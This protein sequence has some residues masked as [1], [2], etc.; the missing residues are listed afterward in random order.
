MAN[1]GISTVYTRRVAG[2]TLDE[3][4]Y[5]G[6]LSMGMHGHEPAFLSAVMT[7]GFTERVALHTTNTEPL[8]VVVRPLDSEHDVTFGHLPT[9]IFRVEVDKQ[10]FRDLEKAGAATTMAQPAGNGEAKWILARLYREFSKR[11]AACSLTL[12]ELV[13]RLLWERPAEAR[14]DGPKARAAREYLDGHFLDPISLQ[15]AAVVLGTHP[16]YLARTFRESF[17]TTVG[18]YLRRLRLNH[19]SDLIAKTDLPLGEVALDAG[20]ADQ[21]HLTRAFG[22]MAGTTP[23]RYRRT[24]RL[25]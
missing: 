6:G 10:A 22:Q 3:T 9:K 21:A 7:G 20:F 24:Y 12:E 15:D 4:V 16:V 25:N 2:F 14:R 5:E 1:Q 19:A 11:E 13:L 17:G 18:E 8:S 23:G